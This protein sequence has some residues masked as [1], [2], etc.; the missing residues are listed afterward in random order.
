MFKQAI[1]LFEKEKQQLE[2]ALNKANEDTVKVLIIQEYICIYYLIMSYLC[3]KY[4]IN[5][6]KILILSRHKLISR[7]EKIFN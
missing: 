7:L 4:K 2:I 1:S 3:N 6:I 5:F